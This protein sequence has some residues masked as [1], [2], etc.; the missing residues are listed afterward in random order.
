VERSIKERPPVSQVTIFEHDTYPAEQFQETAQQ[1]EASTLGMWAFLA[2]EVLFFGGMFLSFYVYRLRWPDV[3]AEGA[4]ELKWYLGTLNTAILLGSSY[5]MALAVHSARHGDI[6]RVLRRLLLTAFIG[7]VFLGIKFT[8]YAIEH[9][10]HLVPALNYS[11]LSPTGQTRPDH[12]PLFM[13]FYFVMTGFHAI[14]MII[15]LAVLLTLAWLTH[16]GKFSA[17]YHNPV[18][19]AGLYWHFVDMV[20]VFL[21][22]TLYLLRHP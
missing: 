2:T 20:W 8:E 17:A 9:R 21:Y 18:E 14:H 11:S 12:L 7:T 4:K 22:P 6:K 13:T 16:R 19:V 1:D 10:N 15:G 3:F 5:T